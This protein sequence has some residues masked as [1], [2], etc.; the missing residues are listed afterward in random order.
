MDDYK[1]DISDIIKT[2]RKRRKL[3]QKQL[4]EICGIRANV[5]STY[6]SGKIRVPS[7][8]LL[9]IM[10]ALDFVVIFRPKEKAQKMYYKDL[11]K[12]EEGNA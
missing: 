1:K 8:N 6:E 5:L 7:D 12:S 3:T 10:E 4:S 11:R 2:C 9:R